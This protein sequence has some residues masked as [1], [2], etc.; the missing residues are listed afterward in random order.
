MAW[1]SVYGN[2]EVHGSQELSFFVVINELSQCAAQVQ[3]HLALSQ[4]HLS[5]AATYIDATNATLMAAPAWLMAY[6]GS[7]V[8][9][10][11]LL[12]SILEPMHLRRDPGNTCHLCNLLMHMQ[13]DGIGI[14]FQEVDLAAGPG[15]SDGYA[16]Y[17]VIPQVHMYTSTKA[18][19]TKRN[20]LLKSES[21]THS[22]WHLLQT[23]AC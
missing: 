5:A 12:D 7:D 20:D 18:S 11:A 15:T 23:C 9:L 21:N 2:A 8:T 6:V 19:F 16:H 14:A 13:L 1:V 10:L 17:D 22:R 4:G 3:R